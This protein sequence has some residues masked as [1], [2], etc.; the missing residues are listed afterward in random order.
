M[1]EA[2]TRAAF[3]W[4]SSGTDLPHGFLIENRCLDEGTRGWKAGPADMT[5]LD[6]G[7]IDPEDLMELPGSAGEDAL[8]GVLLLGNHT[9]RKT[10]ETFLSECQSI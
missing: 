5:C 2:G 10:P 9:V 6:I 8:S 4:A 7:M 1:S 3:S